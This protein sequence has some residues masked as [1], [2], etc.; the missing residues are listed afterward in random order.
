MLF[1]KTIDFHMQILNYVKLLIPYHIYRDEII[2]KKI[3][4]LNYLLNVKTNKLVNIY[5]IT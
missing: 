1:L 2:F 5:S 4:N 3:Y